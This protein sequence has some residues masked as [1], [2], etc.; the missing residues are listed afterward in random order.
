MLGAIENMKIFLCTG[1]G[2]LKSFAGGGVS[3]KTQGLCQG[4]GAS[5]AGWAI[6]SICILRA[7]GKKGHGAKLLCP[8]P[9]LQH[10]LLAILYVNDTNLLHVDLAKDKRVEDV[11]HAIQESVN[12]WGNLLIVTGGVLQ[13][14]KCFYSIILFKW[15]NGEWR[16]TENNIDG[17]FGIT[18]PLS[19]GGKAAISQKSVSHA[20]KTLGAMTSLDRNSSANIQMMQNKAQQRINNVRSGNLHH[21]NV[22][23]LLKVQFWPRVGYGL[24][25]FTASLQELERALHKQ[26][27]QILPL[28]G[29]IRTTPVES[30][31]INYQ[32]RVLW[33]RSPT[34][35]H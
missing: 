9:K 19:G 7:H 10:H 15:A 29:I 18:L 27:Y 16:Y 23:F 28:G 6:I 25:S 24:C 31:T 33:H 21:Q 4:N 26:Y 3:I 17:G 35:W 8:I 14:S 1:F 32:R 20:K 5:P 2:D 12:S 13:P 34:P 11:H 22:W 30:R